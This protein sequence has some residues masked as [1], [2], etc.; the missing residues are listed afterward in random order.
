MLVFCAVDRGAIGGSRPP[1]TTLELFC[2]VN[3][4]SPKWMNSLLCLF[5]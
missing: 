1:R 2:Q 5:F 3:S 4:M